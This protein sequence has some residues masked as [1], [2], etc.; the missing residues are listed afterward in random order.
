[1]EKFG[2]YVT[3]MA[4]RHY[5]VNL[6]KSTIAIQQSIRAWL[7]QSH[8]KVRTISNETQKTNL[9]GEMAPS[10]C[11]QRETLKE[12]EDR[13]DDLQ[14]AAA[15]TIQFFWKDYIISKSMSSQ[16]IA[17]TKIQ[18]HYRGWLM[19]KSF[20]CKRQAIRAIQNSWKEYTVRKSIQIQQV[21]A[22]KIQS[23]Y[24]GCLMRRSFAVRMQAIRTIQNFWKDYIVYKS[25][26]SHHVA[27]TK[28][29]SHY[30][31]RLMR[32]SYTCKKQA[33]RAIQSSWKEYM[34]NKTIRSQH[35]AATKI[36]SQCRG[37]LERKKF[38]C[39]KQA[40]INIQ[41]IFQCMSS[42]REF[43]MYR[44][45]NLSAIIIQ[46]HFRGWRARREVYREKHIFS[47]VQVSLYSPFL[48]VCRRGYNN[49]IMF[50]SL[51]E[52]II[53]Y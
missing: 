9:I 36:Q 20:A 7:A 29:Q 28:I 39:R 37:W 25:I 19:K 1:M 22:T 23:C 12:K 13:V 32:R 3:L 16:H 18:S 17:A 30:R 4:D 10:I 46:S 15:L 42:R 21:A 35:V 26:Q 8:Y 2:F 33:V 31:S 14:S 5:F 48:V 24:R 6:K 38:A 52:D 43:L 51:L 53:S 27:A 50:I 34:V 49:S 40:V 47:R 45:E 44:K 11:A 41:R